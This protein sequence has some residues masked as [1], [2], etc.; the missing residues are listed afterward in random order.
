[1]VTTAWM[2]WLGIAAGAEPPDEPIPAEQLRP[3]E[4]EQQAQVL[5]RALQGLRDALVQAVAGPVRRTQLP[6]GGV[7]LEA[8]IE[9]AWSEGGLAELIALL[10]HPALQTGPV[11]VPVRLPGGRT[12]VLG[13][14]PE[15]LGSWDRL[16][17][18]T[19][20]PSLRVVVED[21]R[22]TRLATSPSLLAVRPRRLGLRGFDLARPPQLEQWFPT[23]P[24]HPT[25]PG[26]RHTAEARVTV[27]V[28]APA[29]T[30]QL[31]VLR[32]LDVRWDAAAPVVRRMELA[33]ELATLDRGASAAPTPELG[34]ARAGVDVGRCSAAE[35]LARSAALLGDPDAIG[36]LGEALACQGRWD[37]A[38]WV[39]RQHQIPPSLSLIADGRT[40]ALEVRIDGPADSVDLIGPSLVAPPVAQDGVLRFTGLLPGT[41]RLRPDPPEGYAS[42]GSQDL[43][44]VAG[45]VRRVQVS[46]HPLGPAQLRFTMPRFDPALQVAVLEPPRLLPPGVEVDSVHT[47]ARIEYSLPGWAD[48]RGPLRI[49][50]L[51]RLDAPEQ[52]ELPA[53]V[54][55]QAQ[56]ALMTG[57]IGEERLT[58]PEGGQRALLLDVPPGTTTVAGRLEVEGYGAFVGP[59]PVA[60]GQLTRLVLDPTAL[61][62]WQA[63]LRARDAGERWLVGA[64][65]TG[66]LA[67][68]SVLSGTASAE[69]WTAA[70]QAAEQANQA[71][72]DDY[73]D[74]QAFA[75]ESERAELWSNVWLGCAI[76]AG[77]GAV[78][79]GLT[80]VLPQS[81]RQ[82]R[83]RKEAERTRN[84]TLPLQAM[85][86]ES[87]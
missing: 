61:P 62:A 86:V 44:L 6:D 70:Q 10:E 26:W 20:A 55:L 7:E 77:V 19:L 54:V 31:V 48:G 73:A 78:A 80:V 50:D 56:H 60:P 11:P 14:Q 17:E 66:A 74:Y 39:W 40:A 58:V 65:A 71:D 51:P 85:V 36:L 76:G 21:G 59:V 46:L 1:M 52:L 38:L 33:A 64:M 5:L 18:R 47:P 2:L 15:L 12:L 75:A 13:L 43:S 32:E 3:T 83:A 8:R 4:D 24:L 57:V 84:A 25:D 37:E 23:P 28:T 22:G 49:Q 45:E 63:E 30:H 16:T 87:P 53:A 34:L 41:Y 27:R 72:L 35:P 82:I 29:H 68:A 9:T 81:I 42:S 67:M 69:R 79:T